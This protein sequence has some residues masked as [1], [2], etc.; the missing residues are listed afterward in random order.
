MVKS[1]EIT[2]HDFIKTAYHVTL[3]CRF[4]TGQRMV[5]TIVCRSTGAALYHVNQF[6][7]KG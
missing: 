4:S 2:R 7:M 1:F 6:M 3:I 5:T